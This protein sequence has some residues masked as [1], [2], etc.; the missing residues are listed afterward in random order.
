M[1]GREN[2]GDKILIKS[3]IF[4]C[5]FPSLGIAAVEKEMETHSS[6]LA[7]K[8]PWTEKPGRL[9]SMGMQSWTTERLHFTSGIAAEI[10]E[11]FFKRHF[12]LK[13]WRATFP[14]E[15]S[16]QNRNSWNKVNPNLNES[17]VYCLKTLT[18]NLWQTLDIMNC[19]KSL[20]SGEAEATHLFPRKQVL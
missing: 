7:W 1:K 13:M 19:L 10:S 5:N 8:I 16:S 11:F 12:S 2:E 17:W 3:N 9:Q 18:E 6:S 14:L 15:S 4:L 20:K